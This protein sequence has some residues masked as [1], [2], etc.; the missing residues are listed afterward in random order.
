[1]PLRTETG[2][3]VNLCRLASEGTT[4]RV[5]L[6]AS[7]FAQMQIPMPPMP[8]QERIVAH[9]DAIEDRLIRAQM[10]REEQET[11]LQAALRSAFHRL[12]AGADLV[13]MGD[14]APVHRRPMEI[15][16][17]GHYPELGSLLRERYFPQTD[18]ARGIADLAKA[19]PS[20]CG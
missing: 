11:E 6:K 16:L 2:F 5:R 3:F 4:N 1:M 14:I 8:E 13:A 10:R 18:P 9:L 20:A 17:E 7:K 19:F 12:Q 15:S